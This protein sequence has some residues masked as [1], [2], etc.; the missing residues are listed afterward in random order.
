MVIKTKQ[1]SSQGKV[2]VKAGIAADASENALSRPSEVMQT[3][4]GATHVEGKDRD[5]APDAK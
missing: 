4:Q 1:S 5:S 3:K 2:A